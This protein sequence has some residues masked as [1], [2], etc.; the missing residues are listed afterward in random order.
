ML[1]S[2]IARNANLVVEA[3]LLPKVAKVL[4]DYCST[5]SKEAS[6]KNFMS[7]HELFR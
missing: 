7:F 3:E 5:F 4:R 2:A 1:G 6:H